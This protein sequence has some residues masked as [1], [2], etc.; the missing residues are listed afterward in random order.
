MASKGKD[1][2][3]VNAYQRDYMA[4]RRA[5][6]RDIKEI[7][8]VA[9]SARRLAARD[10]FAE[11]CKVY[12]PEQFTLP[13]SEYH[14]RAAEKIETAVR[15]GGF[16][17]FAMP[18]GSGK[19]TMCRWAVLWA[20]LTGQIDYVVLVGA[21][22]KAAEKQL[23]SIK[24]MLCRNQLLA[25]DFPEACIPV[26][27]L[28]E[29]SVLPGKQTF[30]GS[31]T[32]VEWQANRIVMPWIPLDRPLCSGAFG[33]VIEVFGITSEI[34]GLNHTKPDN[35]NI[36]PQLALADDP[37]TRESARSPS[38]SKTR[39]ETLVG[40]IAY[41]AGPGKPIAIVCPCT[42]IY[43]DDMADQLLN[44]ET[45]PE[46]RGERTKM[47]ESF[48]SNV[49]LWDRYADLFRD[50]LRDTGTIESATNYYRDNREKMDEGARVS[51]PERFRSD[52]L[53]GIQHAINLKLRDEAAFFAECQNDPIQEVSELERLTAAEIEAKTTGH[54]RMQ[55]PNE[56]SFV[57][58]YTDIQGD[59]LYWM[60]CGFTR[61]F[62]GFVLDYGA[63]P[64][65]NRNYFT[66]ANARRTL[67]RT[68]DGDESAKVYA[69]LSELGEHLAG[70][71]Y[72][73][74]DGNTLRLSRWCIDNN[75]P[76]RRHAVLAWHAQSRH[77]NVTTLTYGR[78]ITASKPPIQ[79]WAKYRQFGGGPG[80]CWSRDKGQ[81]PSA[82]I[83]TNFWKKRVHDAL[84][85]PAGN[86]GALTL[87][88]PDKF[89]HRMLADHISSEKPV[90]TV[91]AERVVY[92][93]HESIGQDNHLFDC[94]V[95]CFAAASMCGV[96]RNSERV[97][98][99]KPK[100]RNK[101]SYL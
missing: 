45:H 17:G 77:A 67:S 60:L 28:V 16:F 98:V 13:W 19:T 93:F 11:F 97:I 31:P 82:F 41:L 22:E 99:Q 33:A 61:E 92:E 50:G 69:A 1:R 30:Q 48:P 20:V 101:V 4:R 64:E 15:E 39:L 44:R 7:P 47:V 18:R 66:L 87:F 29:Q 81:L 42:V 3:D 2:H 52:E 12:F 34:R 21:T 23:R 6:A 54:S 36:R 49:D 24:T 10:S 27:Q 32:F 40:D 38:Q 62:T 95:G 72:A 58:A 25:A 96:S 76:Q 65:Q 94:L 51:W 75:W 83:D 57:T 100:K 74:A 70:R 91:A 85:L 46:W 73:T 79:E 26:R 59:L 37:Q 56:C 35:T 90:K 71:Q 14:Y 78:G 88:K 63:W 86:K 43:P 9:D 89:G 8:P 84:L 53:S 68:Y 55:V 5:S 80:W